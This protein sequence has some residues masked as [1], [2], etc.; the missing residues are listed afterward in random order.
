MGRR[1][2]TFVFYKKY[3]PWIHLSMENYT[4]R[5]PFGSTKSK[6]MTKTIL[7]KTYEEILFQKVALG[8]VLHFVQNGSSKHALK[9]CILAHQSHKSESY[10]ARL[11]FGSTKKC[12]VATQTILYERYR[13]FLFQKV[14]LF[15]LLR[16]VQDGP[17]KNALE[18]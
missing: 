5:L 1:S 4:A 9:T 16:F 11:P 17:S 10:T 12:K 6:V 13:E 7:Y 18:T 3:V 14:A 15:Y 8:Y 2:P